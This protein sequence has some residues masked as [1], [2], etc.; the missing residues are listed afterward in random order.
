MQ[1]CFHSP[2]LESEE[3]SRTLLDEQD[4]EDEDG[5]LGEDGAGD[6]LEK[7]VGD[8]ERKGADQCPPQVADSAKD[9]D[10]ETVDDVALPEIRAHVVDRRQCDAG[11]AA[12]AGAKPK[13]E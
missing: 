5:D 7:L 11:D 9:H 2:A 4:D 3:T 6:R 12:N 8:T 1:S 13:R 10:H